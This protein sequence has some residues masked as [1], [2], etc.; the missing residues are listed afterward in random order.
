MITAKIEAQADFDAWRTTAR[1]LLQNEIAPENVDWEIPGSEGSLFSD[2]ADPISRLKAVR[3][4][5]KCPKAFV[6]I[7]KRV[8]CFRDPGRFARLY[9]ILWRLQSDRTLLK[10]TVDPDVIWLTQCDKAVRRDRHKMHAF[11]RF[12]IVGLGQ[13]RREQFAA[14][15]EPTHYITEL[16]APFFK[17]RFP[18]MD[19]VIV[20]PD[21]TAIWNGTDLHFTPGGQK[22]EVPEEDAIEDHWK[23]YFNSIFNPARLKVGAMIAEMPKKYWKNMPEAIDIPD[24]IQSARAR[25][26]AMREHGVTTAN[27]MAETLKS[28]MALQAAHDQK[29]KTLADAKNAVQSCRRCPLHCHASQA[30]FGEGP[31]N[32]RLMIVGEQPGDQE[33]IAGRPFVGPAGGVLNAALCE[34]GIDRDAAYVTNAVKHFKFK[35]R[36]KRRIHERPSAG[37][38]DHCRWWLETEK[39]L[40]KPDIV[41]TL[42]ASA[43]RAILGKNV[44]ISDMRGE[45]HILSDGTKLFAT[46]HPAFLLRLTDVRRRE[47]ELKSFVN[48]LRQARRVL[49]RLE[50]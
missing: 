31:K 38:I 5:I 37:E 49:D 43:V 17:R 46:V 27:P 35:V 45:A 47:E 7:G 8:I 21:C 48:D 2:L 50:T 18:N 40:V 14:W 23:T 16:A 22:S 34:A 15:F 19:W 30:V 10:N 42:G 24:M 32:A 44:R 36:G 33:D 6:E 9:T 12:R 3:S 26:N 13:F 39:R 25:E 1:L 41:L 20:T 4:E 28:R 11:V 29:F